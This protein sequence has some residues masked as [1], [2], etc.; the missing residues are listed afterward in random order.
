M[1]KWDESKNRPISLREQFREF[2]NTQNDNPLKAYSPHQIRKFT[3]D[4]PELRMKDNPAH[5]QLVQYASELDA[6]EM[7]QA[8]IEQKERVASESGDVFIDSYPLPGS[9]AYPSDFI[10]TGKMPNSDPVGFTISQ[11]PRNMVFGGPNGSGKT[12]CLRGILS[13]PKLLTSTRIIAFGKKREL[14]GL[15]AHFR[16][17]GYVVVF[18]MEE[19]NLAFSQPPRGTKDVIWSN[20]LSKLTGQV[21][22]RLSA[23]RLMNDKLNEL[24]ANHPPDLYPTLEQLIITIEALKPH[25][26][27]REFQYKESILFCLRDLLQCTGNIWNY[28][29]SD[30]L[31][32][33]LS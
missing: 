26:Y 8:V 14:R 32:T 18:Q 2:Q 5:M 25:V 22:G 20:E 17:S 24:L 27:S 10:E 11:T 9:T 15:V 33:L 16:N 13:D 30:F 21:Y 23:H 12:T 7:L 19:L 6:Q 3:D 4:H 29:S 28:G 31:E 1:N